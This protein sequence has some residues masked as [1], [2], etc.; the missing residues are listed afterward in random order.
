MQ[1]TRENGGKWGTWGIII[2]SRLKL[3]NTFTQL[4]VAGKWRK[5]GWGNGI[6][7]KKNGRDTPFRGPF[8]PIFPEAP[9]FPISSLY[10]TRYPASEW[11][12]IRKR[13]YLG[14]WH[15]SHQQPTARN[16]I[17][18]PSDMV[19]QSVRLTAMLRSC[20]ADVD[21][22]TGAYLCHS[23]SAHS[24]SRTMWGG[25]SMMAHAPGAGAAIR[26]WALACATAAYPDQTVWG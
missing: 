25:A 23:L 3:L 6:K 8:S 4:Q 26:E 21:C 7:R 18:D 10:K 16:T 9:D 14:G 22:W 20:S 24:M 13:G 12:R 19:P 15:A 17:Q 5:M 1:K 2:R 11:K